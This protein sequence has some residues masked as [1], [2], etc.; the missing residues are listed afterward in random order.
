MS[1]FCFDVNFA[2]HEKLVPIT[3]QISTSIGPVVEAI[4][5]KRVEGCPKN[6]PFWELPGPHRE[7]EHGVLHTFGMSPG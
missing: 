5:L 7:R 4:V 1:I 3:R 2:F 6:R